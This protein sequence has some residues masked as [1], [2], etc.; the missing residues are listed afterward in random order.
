MTADTTVTLQLSHGLHRLVIE[1]AGHRWA[2]QWE[3]GLEHTVIEHVGAMAKDPN[4][5]LGW[6]EAAIVCRYVGRRTPTEWSDPTKPKR[7][8]K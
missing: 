3:P 7:S 1:K 2:F 6:V 5:P 8:A 4:C